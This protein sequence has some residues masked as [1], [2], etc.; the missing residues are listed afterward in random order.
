MKLLLPFLLIIFA[1]CDRAAVT[2]IDRETNESR[3]VCDDCQF[4]HVD[5]RYVEIT[6]KHDKII[7]PLNTVKEVRR[8]TILTAE[9]DT[10][11][12]K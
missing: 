8:T 10:T 3:V 5:D 2:V 12:E 9:K 6:T 4:F 11:G 1:G 7:I